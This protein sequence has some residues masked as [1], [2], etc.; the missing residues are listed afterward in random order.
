MNLIIKTCKD[1]EISLLLRIR[2]APVVETMRAPTNK[3]T[4][5]R[6]ACI[7]SQ[8]DIRVSPKLIAAL[9]KSV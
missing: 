3:I 6:K 7:M 2:S 8:I 5:V 4:K 1:G 9:S